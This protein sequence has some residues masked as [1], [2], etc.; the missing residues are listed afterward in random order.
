MG[1][2]HVRGLE[3]LD[4]PPD[5]AVEHA[6]DLLDRLGA[7]GRRALE[8]ARYPLPPRLARML[9]EAMQRGAGDDA[10]R[11]AALLGSGVRSGRN[12]L[13]AALDE[14][15][16]G[17]ALQQERQLRR[18]ARVGKETASDEKTLL[19]SVLAGFPDRVARLRSG[20]QV[21]LSTGMSAEV[22]G[23]RPAYEFMVVVDAEDRKDKPLPLARMTSRIEPEWL[24]DLFPERLQEE[25]AL[26]VES[27]GTTSGCR[28]CAALRPACDLGV[29]GRGS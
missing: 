29:T 14:E 18:V 22:A 12:D 5:A 2:A 27:R 21:L 13:L 24:I 23:E 10:V 7:E 11:A 20:N 3:W 25:V 1:I 15:L 4:I 28:K 9:V 19:I 16:D 8:M 6:E 26:R 17:R